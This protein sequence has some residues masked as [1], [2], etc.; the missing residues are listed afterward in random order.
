MVV[1]KKQV[2]VALLALMMSGV[3]TAIQRG[4][5]GQA[6][7]GQVPPA[8]GAAGQQPAAQGRGGGGARG[9][10]AETTPVGVTIAGEV[11]NFVPV[12]DEMLVKPDPANWPMIRR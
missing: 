7:A 3:L 12:T 1:T 5:A 9:G 11:P 4:G 8:P 6:P 10:A 2:V